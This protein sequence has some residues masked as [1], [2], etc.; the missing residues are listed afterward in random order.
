MTKYVTNNLS[1]ERKNRKKAHFTFLKLTH[2]PF[3]YLQK[4]RYFRKLNKATSSICEG[5]GRGKKQQ[6]WCT[7]RSHLNQI[8]SCFHSTYLPPS[9][10]I[11]NQHR[12]T[13]LFGAC[14]I[15]FIL[16][17]KQKASSNC[18]L[19]QAYVLGNVLSRTA[20]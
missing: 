18:P 9:P 1:F 11:V 4:T 3:L 14:L 6:L 5:K 13:G 8:I 19:V 2:H 17:K 16:P 12:Y 20:Q 15:T 7:Y 10:R